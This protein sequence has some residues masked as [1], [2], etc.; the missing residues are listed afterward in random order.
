MANTFQMNQ[1]CTGKNIDQFNKALAKFSN[2]KIIY[3]NFFRLKYH[4]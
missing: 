3:L 4:G 1:S 2:G